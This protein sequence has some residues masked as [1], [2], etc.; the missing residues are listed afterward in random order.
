MDKNSKSSSS[1]D[2]NSRKI[3]EKYENDKINF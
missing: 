3:D 1:S 2:D